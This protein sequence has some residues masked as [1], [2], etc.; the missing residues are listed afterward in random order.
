MQ[1]W[2]SDR[3][4]EAAV[5]MDWSRSEKWF[6]EGDRIYRGEKKCDK[7]QFEAWKELGDRVAPKKVLSNNE[8]T[9]K[10][11]IHINPE[12]VHKALERQKAIE[13]EILKESAA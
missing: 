12:S 9:S 10:I 2:I 4:K 1:A 7:N 11:E 8:P 5:Q 3:A 6:F 13:A